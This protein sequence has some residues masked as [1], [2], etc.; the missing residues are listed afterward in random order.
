MSGKNQLSL[1]YFSLL[2]SVYI[3]VGKC[4]EDI[5][6]LS[7]CLGNNIVQSSM[8]KINISDPRWKDVQF[9]F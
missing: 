2:Y 1:L 5:R 6:N 4:F 8:L 7:N 9:L 3:L